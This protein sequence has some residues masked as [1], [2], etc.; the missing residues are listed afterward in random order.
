VNVSTSAALDPIPCDT[1]R[2][3]EHGEVRLSLSQPLGLQQGRW[4]RGAIIG[5]TSRR[6]F[7]NHSGDG[8]FYQH[9]LIRYDTSRGDAAVM[10]LAAGAVLLRGLPTV[11]CLRLGPDELTVTSRSV[12][13]SRVLIGPC[14]EMVQYEFTTPYLALNQVNHE[15][16]PRARD[17]ERSALL[18]RI[19]IGNLLSL[20]KSVEL[21]VSTR[22]AVETCLWPTGFE[23]LKPG[24]SLLGFRGSFRVNFLI[25]DHWGIGKSSARGFGT[26]RTQEG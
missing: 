23:E 10:G 22:L 20:S 18:R 2:I 8:F 15:G 17:S 24:V 6:E 4:L 9:P 21:S 16:W 7:H 12:T 1:A 19:L 14:A 11:D 13:A 3:I 26:V 25:P 5:L